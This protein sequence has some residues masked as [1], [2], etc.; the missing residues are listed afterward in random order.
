MYVL[1]IIDIY[2]YIHTHVIYI[3][4]YTVYTLILYIHN[5]FSYICRERERVGCVAVKHNLT[6][7]THTHTSHTHPHTWKYLVVFRDYE[8]TLKITIRL[9]GMKANFYGYPL[10]RVPSLFTFVYRRVAIHIPFILAIIVHWLIL[11]YHNISN[12]YSIDLIYDHHDM[13]MKHSLR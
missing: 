13:S 4:M 2:L 1:Y 10:K 9:H 3:Y 7:S 8:G 11:V 6:S 12:S 5:I